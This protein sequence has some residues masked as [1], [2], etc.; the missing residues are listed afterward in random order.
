MLQATAYWTGVVTAL[1]V[2]TALLIVTETDAM[3]CT[4]SVPLGGV[5]EKVNGTETVNWP[6]KPWDAVLSK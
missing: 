5:P 1:E 3:V 2:P 6:P 4:S